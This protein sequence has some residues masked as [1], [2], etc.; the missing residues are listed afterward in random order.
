[1]LGLLVCSKGGLSETELQFLLSDDLT[2]PVP[3][4]MW[5][6]VRRTLKPFLRNIGGKGQEERLE[7]FHAS[8]QEVR[9]CIL[10]LKESY[11]LP[12]TVTV[13][14]TDL[15][16]FLFNRT[17]LLPVPSPSSTYT[18]AMVGVNPLRI[19]QS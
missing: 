15:K 9:L 6:E 16:H 11:S 10:K 5:A 13:E 2:E 18:L 17:I 8:I 1:M 14:L 12:S 4:M 19:S 3:M 7:F